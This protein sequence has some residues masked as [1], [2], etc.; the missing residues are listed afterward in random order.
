[1]RRLE[2]EAADG[3]AP[4]ASM[5][6]GDRG[7]IAVADEDGIGDGERVAQG[8]QRLQRLDMHV[9]DAARL[10]ERVRL[11]IAEA[12]IDQRGAAGRLREARGKVAPLRQRAE[13]LMEQD[14][15]RRCGGACGDQLVFEAVAL[16]RDERHQSHFE[17]SSRSLKRWI[18][19]VAVFGSS[20]TY[21]KVRGYLYGAKRSLTWCRSISVSTTLPVMPGLTT[22]KAAGLMR[23]SASGTPTTAASSTDTCDSSAPSTSKGAT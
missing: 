9:V 7:A 14:K 5:D 1:M 19:P 10:G 11:S 6:E 2:D 20:A 12:R 4:R 21:T 15:R 18:L 17:A 13:P 22:M 16:D 3:P 23:P 8:R